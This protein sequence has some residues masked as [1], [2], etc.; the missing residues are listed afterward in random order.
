MLELCAWVR[1]LLMWKVERRSN[2]KRNSKD[3]NIE[4]RQENLQKETK[5]ESL[6]DKRGTR[7]LCSQ[8]LNY[9]ILVK[10]SI[11]EANTIIW[12]HKEKA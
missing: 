11:L 4:D 1:L 9:E 3:T 7:S 8:L 6:W 5:S 2:R 12:L 10:H